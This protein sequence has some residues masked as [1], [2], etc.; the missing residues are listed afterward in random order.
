M[1]KKLTILAFGLLLAVGWTSTAS[2]QLLPNAEARHK[3]M[4]VAPVTVKVAE[5]ASTPAQATANQQRGT[6]R[7]NAPLRTQNYDLN[8][9]A[10][11]PKSWYQALD[12]VTWTGGSQN[13]TEPFTTAK[14]M[15]ALLK[16]VYT[17]QDIPGAKHSAPRNCDIPYQTIQRGWNIIGTNYL[18]NAVIEV[19]SSEVYIS[20]IVI[21]DGNGNE[22]RSCTPSNTTFPSSWTTTSNGNYWHTTSSSGGSVGIPAEWMANSYGYAQVSVYC[23]PSSSYYD[24]VE[25]SIGNQTYDYYTFSM[26]KSSVAYAASLSPASMDRCR[27]IDAG[28]TT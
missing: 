27:R 18:D 14:S 28:S 3:E 26:M 15:M 21:T 20:Q 7:A 9:T 12:P 25:I 24:G 6:L 17:D 19:N 2:A 16:R 11:H 1:K 22:L 5:S 10:T 4:R 8:A 23:R 13:I